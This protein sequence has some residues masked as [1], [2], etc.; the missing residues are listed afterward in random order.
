MLLWSLDVGLTFEVLSAIEDA[1]K[2]VLAPLLNCII[3]SIP[4]AQFSKVHVE[5]AWPVKSFWE[6]N[7]LVKLEEYAFKTGSIE[8]LQASD[9]PASLRR[10]YTIVRF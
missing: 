6:D 7:E 4:V 5:V 9:L 2:I 8:V 3:T 10:P 1:G